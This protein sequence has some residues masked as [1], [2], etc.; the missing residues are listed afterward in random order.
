MPL[1]TKGPVRP[2]SNVERLSDPTRFIDQ[3]RAGTR[4]ETS[5]GSLWHDLAA[6]SQAPVTGFQYHEF[7]G[8]SF[9]DFKPEDAL[10]PEQRHLLRYVEDAESPEEAQAALDRVYEEAAAQ[11]ALMDG[12]LHPFV[13][14]FMAAAM[15]PVSYLSLGAGAAYRVGRTAQFVRRSTG[16][17]FASALMAESALQGTQ[18]TRSTAES[19]ANIAASTLFSGGLATAFGARQRAAIARMRQA[20]AEAP[21]VPPDMQAEAAAQY[22]DEMADAMEGRAPT[23]AEMQL[24]RQEQALRDYQQAVGMQQQMQG[25][26]VPEAEDDLF[27]TPGAAPR[28]QAADAGTPEAET[29][30]EG[31]PVDR[32]EYVLSMDPED[33]RLWEG[34]TGATR[35]MQEAWGRLSAVGLAPVSTILATSP[36][37]A[38]RELFLRLGE[39]S[40]HLTNGQAAGR[41]MGPMD[42][43]TAIKADQATWQ[44]R[45]LKA[46]KKEFA[47]YRKRV[48]A[49]GKQPMN[50]LEFRVQVGKALRRGYRHVEPEVAR[51]AREAAQ[52]FEY[53]RQQANEAGLDVTA[54]VKT[55]ETYAPR[56]W[57]RRKIDEGYDVLLD[58]VARRFKE[59]GDGEPEALLKTRAA[60]LIETFLQHSASARAAPA[61]RTDERGSLAQRT[62]MVPDEMVEDFLDNDVES[63]VASYLR[64]MVSDTH[65]KRVFGEVNPGDTLFPRLL[66]D[67][68]SAAK[69]DDPANQGALERR[70]RA[71]LRML[72]WYAD[73]LRGLTVPSRDS[74]FDGLIRMSQA[75]RQFNFARLLGSVVVSSIPDAARLIMQAGFT[76]SFGT[77]MKQAGDGF[78]GLRMSMAQAEKYGTAVDITMSTRVR[79]IMGMDEADPGR[80]NT[81]RALQWTAQKAGLV[82]GMSYWNAAVKSVASQETTDFLLGA[83][84]RLAR[85]GQLSGRDAMRVARLGIEPDELRRIWE[86][87]S[88]KFQDLNGLLNANIEAWS[89]PNLAARFRHAVVREVDNSIITPTG[90]DVPMWADTE[91]GRTIFHLKRFVFTATN[92]TLSAGLQRSDSEFFQ[93]AAVMLALGAAS[94]ALKDLGRTGEIKERPAREWVVNAIDRSGLL[95]IA[96]EADNLQGM[97]T[98]HSVQRMIAGNAADRFARRSVVEQTFGPTAGL[99]R[100]VQ[101]AVGQL[102]DGHATRAD[103]A[104]LRRLAPFM[105]LPGLSAGLRELEAGIAT[106][107][108]LPRTAAEARE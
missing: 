3:M 83:G 28:E 108:Y 91:L 61:Y 4:L 36:F 96:V 7:T 89:N 100:D 13:A 50:A 33:S 10:R 77:A 19:A 53:W 106:T 92:R 107:F 44:T 30:R 79:Q 31:D 52:L 38:T 48:K 88:D 12:P 93:G 71:D 42:L 94:V 74:G 58:I 40:G 60:A 73:H 47:A 57:D 21:E 2:A 95:G 43:D 76:R 14:T 67:E 75:A 55:A 32:F 5:W 102:S 98:G 46:Q 15:D 86:S 29:V 82:T 66:F 34:R 69:L 45:Y 97:F 99:I 65:L 41:A 17:G 11:K 26:R 104:A 85:G 68:V 59:H 78:A 103:I 8:G 37:A 18:L 1:S 87:E 70:G 27:K 63:M 81:E 24:E 23:V 72:R 22:R 80:T 101:A 51:V 20:E 39:P 35:K 6:P 84:R 64:T 62:L 90:A 16:A 9:D 56:M 49:E 54:E 25:P 105:T